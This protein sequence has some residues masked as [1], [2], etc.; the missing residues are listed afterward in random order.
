MAQIVKN[1]KVNLTFNI[2]SIPIT[3]NYCHMTLIKKT[4]CT[5]CLFLGVAFSALSFTDQ[6]SKNI[7]PTGL[8]VNFLLHPDRVFLNGYPTNTE[9]HKAVHYSETFQ[10]TKIEQKQPLFGWLV[11]S[12]KDNTMQT[13]YRI[14]V[15]SS[16]ENIRNNIGDMWDSGKTESEQSINIRYSG[17][18]LNPGNV[19]FWKVKTWDNHNE[20]SSFS[21]IRQFLTAPKLIDYYGYE[22]Y[23]TTRYPLQKTDISPELIKPITETT[24]FI[25]FGKARFGR[26]RIML[27]GEKESDTAKIH[28]GEALKDGRID[29]DPGGSIR[30]ESFKVPLEQGWKTY[31]IIIPTHQYSRMDRIILMP[32]HIGEV[33]PFRY[34]EIEDY[35]GNL[36]EASI[37]QQVSVHYPFNDQA[38]YFHSSDTVLNDVWDLCK[39]TIKATSFAGI[40][41]D[42]DRERFPR[43]GDSYI[44]QLSHYGVE[45]EFSLARHTHEFQIQYS[46][47]WTEWILQVVLMAWADFME[48]GDPTS[49]DHFYKDLKA[50]T[51]KS[52]ARE[53]GLISTRTGLVTP[54]VIKS[55]HWH[56]NEWR[57][58]RRDQP[59][60]RDIVDWP[61]TG[62]NWDV[63][64]ETDGFEFMDIN[65]VVNAFHYRT[66][67]LMS[68]IASA[69][70]KEGDSEFFDKRAEL[71]KES[72]NK[73]LLDHDAGI[74]V[75]GEGSSHSSL[76]ANMF[77]LAF[78]L[79]PEKHVNNVVKFI[80]SR[81][82]A[83]SVYG[84][85]HLL[86]ALYNAGVSEYALELLTSTSERSWGHMI[87]H[88]GTTITLEAWDKK[89]KPNLDWN[90]AWGSAPANIIPR[91]L[92]GIEPLEPGYRKIRI[93]PQPASL[94]TAE[95]RLP[96]IRG[97]VFLSFKNNPG[98]PFLLEVN[99][100]A[101]TE[102]EVY[103]PLFSANQNVT[104]NNRPVSFRVQGDFSVIENVGSGNKIFTVSL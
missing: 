61:Q 59:A 76:H 40:Y 69:L 50:K 54:E 34:C 28:L 98:E 48:T 88:I 45:R 83:C 17:E 104:M 81:G 90:H 74:Y 2:N 21:A 11:G 51:L 101:N 71:V 9:L 32:D 102:A 47:Q 6:G 79:V 85:Q 12:Q 86:N 93:K 8:T 99:I 65:T 25:D 4:I 64:G 56:E 13:A 62:G 30:Y 35:P 60:F 27:Y 52:L 37:I 24:T 26:M 49:M 58:Q 19:Y 31:E 96:T 29:R 97:D 7:Q 82:M 68:K 92:M 94:E 55:V 3:P 77:P 42:G 103:L 38:S 41:V 39:H 95:I 10:F 33:M 53:D 100:P 91:K 73:K 14:M 66:L 18:P 46:S 72:F 70:N 16:Y 57:R 23:G 63:E 67:V 44:N 78:G 36:L 22:Y 75:D 84:A 80:K 5:I 15:S 1:L 87:Y 89:Y 20:E 43:E